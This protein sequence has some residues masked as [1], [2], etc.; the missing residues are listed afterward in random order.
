[1]IAPEIQ[2][3]LDCSV[4]VLN[5]NYMAIRIVRARRAFSL[6]CRELVEVVT[7][8]GRNERVLGGNSALQLFA[9]RRPAYVT[10]GRQI[11][12]NR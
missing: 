8:V 10:L 6:L 4:L 1:M 11:Y 9:R 5:K 3:G 2:S 7:S 12:V